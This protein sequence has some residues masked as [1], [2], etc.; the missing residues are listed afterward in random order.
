MD[1]ISDDMNDRGTSFTGVDI[2]NT[3]WLPEKY[4]PITRGGKMAR[5][6]VGT[7]SSFL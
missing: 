7:L 5:E 6:Y 4:Q 3:F 2:M 1:N